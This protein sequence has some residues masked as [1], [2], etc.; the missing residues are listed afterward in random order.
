MTAVGIL[1]LIGL[2]LL[3]IPLALTLAFISGLYLHEEPQ[4]AAFAL[5]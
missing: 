1:D 4:A 2:V 3:H 5:E